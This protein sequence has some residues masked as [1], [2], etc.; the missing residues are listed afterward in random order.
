MLSLRV[1]SCSFVTTFVSSEGQKVPRVEEQVGMATNPNLVM[2]AT[3]VRSQ[4][5]INFAI[6]FFSVA[7][8]LLK[9][10]TRTTTV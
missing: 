5:P 7:L 8:N 3:V 6:K 10:T 9:T 2:L 4:Q 1:R